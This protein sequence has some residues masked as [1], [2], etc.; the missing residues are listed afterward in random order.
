MRFRLKHLEIAWGGRRSEHSAWVAHRKLDGVVN[1]LTSVRFSHLESCSCSATAQKAKV[2][3]TV[4][5][6]QESIICRCP[7]LLFFA[8]GFRP[9]QSVRP[10][11]AETRLHAHHVWLKY[12][13]NAH[14]P[15][16]R[17]GH[18]RCQLR[19]EA[20]AFQWLTESP[21]GPKYNATSWIWI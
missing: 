5:K 20:N 15:I 2:E 9:L 6:I 14:G 16:L 10:S 4:L 19:D 11:T 7:F 17:I 3:I 18:W 1:L 12:L 8:R 13:W 21:K